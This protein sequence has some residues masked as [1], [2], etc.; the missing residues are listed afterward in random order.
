MQVCAD[1][2]MKKDTHAD[3]ALINK[4]IKKAFTIIYVRQSKR[5]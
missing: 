5:C 4:E 3:S 2:H 1:K